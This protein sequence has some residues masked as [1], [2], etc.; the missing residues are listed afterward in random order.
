MKDF[1]LDRPVDPVAI[2]SSNR[3]GPTAA[4]EYVV[5]IALVSWVYIGVVVQVTLA[6]TYGV[7]LNVVATTY[8][9]GSNNE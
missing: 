9:Y 7:Y 1:E 3:S 5:P 8:I 4:P 6:V 2:M